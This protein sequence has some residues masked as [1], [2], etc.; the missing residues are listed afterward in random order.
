MDAKGG[1]IVNAG[2][3]A[4]GLRGIIAK[5][6]EMVPDRL[7]DEIKTIEVNEVKFKQIPLPSNA[8]RVMYGFRGDYFIIALGDGSAERIVTSLKEARGPPKWLKQLHERL[9]VERPA[10]VSY[11]NVKAAINATKSFAE[12]AGGEV[13]AVALVPRVLEVTGLDGIESISS[14]SGLGE[15]DHV[16]KTLVTTTGKPRG[17][18]NLISNKP[19]TA[20]DLASVPRDATWLVASRFDLAAAYKQIVDVLAELNPRAKEQ[21]EGGLEEAEK[22]LG[23]HPITDLVEPLGDTQL[24]YS[25]PAEGG[26]F[27][28][29][30]AVIA[31]RNRDKLSKVH[32]VLLKMLRAEG[33]VTGPMLPIVQ[34]CIPSSSR[35]RQSTSWIWGLA[36]R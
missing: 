36:C 34:A 25:S 23:F 31:V 7:R 33:A 15:T 12:A 20:A 19:L 13:P 32:D 24:F 6:E 3:R 8:P 28:G 18:L 4:E 22:R 11:L 14:V 1:L 16:T 35:A 2:P 17:L 9:P 21:I 26:M 10:A 27:F 29:A 5:F 30:T